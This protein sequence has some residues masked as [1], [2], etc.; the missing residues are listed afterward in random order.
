[1]ELSFEQQVKLVLLD[2]A[3]LTGIGAIAALWAAARIERYKARQSLQSALARKRVRRIESLVNES[4]T[5]LDLVVDVAAKRVVTRFESAG[6]PGGQRAAMEALAITQIPLLQ[7][8]NEARYL[9]ERRV[10]RETFWI[11]S[12]VKRRVLARI[13]EASDIAEAILADIERRPRRFPARSL[14]IVRYLHDL[15]YRL[16]SRLGLLRGRSTTPTVDEVIRSLSQ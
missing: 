12:D 1:M 5:L 4:E 2:K 6:E 14:R 11:T 3:L 13:A 7:D 9:L 8:F 16:I 15:K 10:E